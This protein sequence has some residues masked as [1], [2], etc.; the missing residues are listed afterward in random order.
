MSSLVAQKLRHFI[1]QQDQT[2][3]YILLLYYFDELN[4]KEISLVLEL[5]EAL[6]NKR[7]GQLQQQA[8]QQILLC[9]S[10][11]KSKMQATNLSA[12]A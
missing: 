12:I 4:I 9:Q 1:E 2:S 5:S 11:S 6:V 3:R 8:Q 10:A 7:L